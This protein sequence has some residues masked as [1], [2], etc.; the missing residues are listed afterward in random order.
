MQTVCYQPRPFVRNIGMISTAGFLVLGIW[1]VWAAAVDLDESFPRPLLAAVI[2]GVF[3]SAMT[4]VGVYVIVL[5]YKYQL[6]VD[7]ESVRQGGVFREQHAELSRVREFRWRRFPAGGSVKLLGESGNLTIEFTNV[8]AAD[9][10]E[11]I[12]RFRSRIPPEL[13]VGW[14]EFHGER[15]EQKKRARRSQRTIAIA[16]FTIAIGFVGA[17]IVWQETSL[18]LA[19]VPNVLMAVYLLRARRSEELNRS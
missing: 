7:D 2:F 1:S 18:V 3:W 4:C 10:M 12:T 13:Q 5:Y 16:F 9:R 17:G 8:S 6:C 11:L 15:P 14:D 19:A